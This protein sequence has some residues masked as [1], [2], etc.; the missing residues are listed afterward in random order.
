MH[1]HAL[2]DHDAPAHIRACHAHALSH[3]STTHYLSLFS[4]GYPSPPFKIAIL[5]EADSMTA[6]AQT[7]LR[8][9]ME[10]YSKTTRFCLICNYVTR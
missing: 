1:A 8:R 2:S 10:V 6:D 3:T 9:T 4:R 7:A 5:D